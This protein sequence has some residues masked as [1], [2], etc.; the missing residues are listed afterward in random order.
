MK[1]KKLKIF[2]WALYIIYIFS[3]GYFGIKKSFM[4]VGLATFCLV[5]TI[6]LTILYAKQVRFL[7]K[8]LYIVLNLI[9][10]FSILLGS[11]YN[12]Y[13][14]NHYDDFLHFWSGFI[15]VKIGWNL[16]RE[17]K[18]KANKN[19]IIFFFIILLITMGIA[20]IFEIVEYSM[21]TL[22]G[23]KT[24]VGG[25]KDTMQ[26]MIDAL[27]GGIIMIIYY[28]NKLRKENNKWIFK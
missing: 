19:K 24:Q 8:S 22:F 20:S 16:F 15:G 17:L 4:E 7:D 10:L 6:I 23:M 25:L 2:Q 1:D 18:V 5:T 21:D 27:L 12:L 28:I 3:I 9:I 11:S 26:D 13:K 14:I